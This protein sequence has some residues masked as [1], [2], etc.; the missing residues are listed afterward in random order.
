MLAILRSLFHEANTATGGLPGEIVMDLRRAA[1]GAQILAYLTAAKIA[2]WPVLKG[3]DGV[4]AKR[5]L[6]KL[7]DDRVCRSEPLHMQA[8]IRMLFVDRS[9]LAKLVDGDRMA[10]STPTW[11][12]IV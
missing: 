4:K 10:T 1:A 6:A 9:W 8:A 7:I 12:E 11:I 2:V 3:S 5:R